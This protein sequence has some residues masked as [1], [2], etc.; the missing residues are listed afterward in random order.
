M[1]FKL[2]VK[3]D[4]GRILLAVNY[5]VIIDIRY[6]VLNSKYYMSVVIIIITV[7]IYQKNYYCF[8]YFYCI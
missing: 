2:M 5:I 8:C 7:I 6:L 1:K 3:F 4:V